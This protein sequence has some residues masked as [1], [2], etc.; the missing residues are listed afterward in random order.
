MDP[1]DKPV[2]PVAPN[3]NSFGITEERFLKIK[4]ETHK[5]YS[6]SLDSLF[7]YLLF[8]VIALS[9]FYGNFY[10]GFF[11]VIF[12]PFILTFIEK[13][14]KQNRLTK[15]GDLSKFEA[16]EK[17]LYNFSCQKR[18]Y[19]SAL[20]NYESKLNQI[21]AIKQRDLNRKNFSYWSSLD[22]YEFEREIA[23]LFEQHGFKTKVTKGSG[24]GGIDIILFKNS[25]AGI[26]QC[27]RHKTKISPSVIRDIYGTMLGGKYK[28]AYVV[29][30]AGF[31]EESMRFSRGKKI[32]LIGLKR[33]M[34][35]VNSDTPLKFLE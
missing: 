25:E 14:Y 10:T 16:Y 30:P 27:K 15:I 2:S 23:V 29:C 31:S 13:I 7:M 3:L 28:F 5:I 22:P 11:G 18:E 17:A 6:F 32:Q 24:D 20:K 21:E 12:F 4:D 33:I 9:Y 1:P 35:M 8:L 26:V 34:E 19:E